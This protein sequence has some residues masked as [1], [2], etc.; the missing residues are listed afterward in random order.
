MPWGMS[1]SKLEY[2]LYPCTP[3][4]REIIDLFSLKSQFYSKKV[5]K[6]QINQHSYFLGNMSGHVL[7]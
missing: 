2:P 3:F 6:R 5:N 4:S 1:F 7:S